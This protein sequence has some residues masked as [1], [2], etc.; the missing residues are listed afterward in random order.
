MIFLKLHGDTDWVS[1][2]QNVIAVLLMRAWR[3]TYCAVLVAVADE[4]VIAAS[5][6]MTS[7]GDGAESGARTMTVL[8]E[9]AV[10]PFWSVA[11]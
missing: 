3:G 9:V 2:E 6:L 5:E 7:V 10:W 11:T 8:V 1:P 4:D